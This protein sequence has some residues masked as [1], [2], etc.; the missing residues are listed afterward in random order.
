VD[1]VDG[2]I[3]GGIKVVSKM[4]GTRG[5]MVIKYGRPMWE[6]GSEKR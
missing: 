6:I 2:M 1:E 5:K 4:A 3:C